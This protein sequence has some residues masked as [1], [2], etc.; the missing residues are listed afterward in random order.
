MILG[1]LVDAGLP[2]QDLRRGI[3]SL[4]AGKYELRARPVL[5]AGVHATKVDVITEDSPRSSLSLNRIHRTIVSSRLPI[6]V[7]DR[8]REV[9]ERLAQAEGLAHRVRP[10]EVQ[11]HEVGV[12]D[13]LV[14]VLGSLLGC[15][16]LGVQRVTASA[17]NL[18]A[19]MMRSAHGKL[20][21]PGPAVAALSRGLPVYSE[22]P[23]RELTT[24]TGIALLATL[25]DDFGPMP[26]MRVRSTGY[27]AGSA[28]FGAWPNVLR[29]FLGE[30]WPASL[31]VTETLVQLETNLDD[32]NPQLYEPVMER[33]F[34]A[35]AV[36]VSLTP[37]IMK[38]GRPG[39]L[40]AALVPRGKA[41]SA[42]QVVLRE[43]TTL[44]VRMQE[45][46]RWVLPRHFESVRTRS[47]V[48]RVKV[49]ETNQGTRKAAPEYR[50]CKR[51]ADR[52][53]RPV[54][55][56]MEEALRAFQRG[57]GRKQAAATRK[58]PR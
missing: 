58:G 16:V 40:L 35:G 33:L 17:V 24:P 37:V 12:V 18:G 11:F 52:T 5:R 19:G 28:N 27:G 34:A 13:S 47:G 31:G 2:L 7:K 55:E 42:A 41:A 44:G 57:T 3:G 36:D 54:R 8:A 25:T 15:H 4:Q 49:A 26:L 9:F 6:P 30:A 23:E 56:I 39:I 21:V 50:D 46:S 10:S 29:I 20:P 38:Q 48:V 1:A 14:D 53:G 43:T 32:L 22:G 51:V 45:V